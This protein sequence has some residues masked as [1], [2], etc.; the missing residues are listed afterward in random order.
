MMTA[1]EASK[2]PK[3][4]P[5]FPLF[6]HAS[7]RWAKKIHGRFVYFGKWA[8]DPKGERALAQYLE[9]RDDLHAGRLR[10]P[11]G[12]H[13][14]TVV[15][16]CSD[17]LD[18]KEALVKAGEIQSRTF[19]GLR[20][21][22]DRIVEHFGKRRLVLDLGPRDFEGL[23]AKLAETLGPVALGNRIQEV[24]SVF[25]YG[26]E[27]ELID[28]PV[29][30]GP[31]FRKPA[32][33]VVRIARAAN[34]IHMFEAAEIR[35]ILGAVDVQLRAAVLLGINAAM[36]QQDI[37]DL[38]ETA[39]DFDGG[40]L[41]FAR[42]KTGVAR[43]IPLWPETLTALRDAI[44]HRPK[45]RQ[46]AHSGLVLLTRTGRPWVRDKPGGEHQDSLGPEFR[47]VLKDIGIY[48]LGRGFYDLRRTFQTIADD[49]GD[50]VATSAVMGHAPKS[51]DMAAT[52]RQRISDSR[53][54]TVTEHVRGWVFGK[55]KQR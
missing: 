55:A 48:R 35:A 11:K 43:R 49:G 27:A 1:K 9:E 38:P 36:G 26:Y 22:A 6:A 16:L 42:G 19:R 13:G 17:F 7:G 23:R 29:R 53:L 45:P 18:S 40:W 3:P 51:G 20:R 28:R 24:R 33:R 39:T 31:T 50:P 41:T 4:Y 12:E 52:Y 25:R 44:E 15:S 21:T 5:T 34:G 8:D 37:A 14:P 30:F 10:R 47:D 54:R 46:K 32:Q 2:P